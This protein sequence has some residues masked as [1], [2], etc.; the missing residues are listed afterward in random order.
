MCK[1]PVLQ[2]LHGQNIKWVG[3]EGAWY[4][5]FVDEE[6]DMQVNVRTTG[7]LPEDFP[8]RQYVTGVSILHHGHSMVIEVI[9]PY[10]G[11]TPGCPDGVFPC[12]ADGGLRFVVDG[13][14][15]NAFLS[16]IR[17]EIVE[18]AFELSSSNLPLEC[19]E[20]GGG[21][22]WELLYEE[23]RRGDRELA[24]PSFEEWVLSYPHMVAP[25]WCAKYIS[26]IG[27]ADEQS[28][29]SVLRI[30]TADVIIRFSVGVNH[31]QPGKIDRFG[32]ELPELD[33][34]QSSV[35]LY[36]INLDNERLTG[37]LGETARP[38]R[39]TNGE[40][41]TKGIKAMRGI[42]ADYRVSSPVGKNFALLHKDVSTMP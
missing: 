10:S 8:N 22:E 27:L 32:R 23:M 37:I 14:E 33:F 11:D 41:I 13:Q 17:N 29:Q 35:G 16:P 1:D 20:F 7:P 24:E 39:D 28:K 6:I 26:E 31:R 42:V 12:L 15:S 18:D 40:V 30:V 9:E 38:V 19:H 36:G 25:E 21:E 34:W 2:G 5:L 4:A 3:E